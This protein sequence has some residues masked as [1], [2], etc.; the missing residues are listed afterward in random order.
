M[1]PVRYEGHPAITLCARHPPQQSRNMDP[2]CP[3]APAVKQHGFQVY[4]Y[5]VVWLSHPAIVKAAVT[6]PHRP[7]GPEEATRIPQACVVA[8]GP[9][10]STEV[11]SHQGPTHTHTHTVPFLCA[12]HAGADV[13]G[14]PRGGRSNCEQRDKPPLIVFLNPPSS[15]PAQWVGTPPPPHPR[16]EDSIPKRRT[17]TYTLL[18]V[19]GIAPTFQHGFTDLLGFCAGGARHHR[20]I[21]KLE[22]PRL[23]RIRRASQPR[24]S[25]E[26]TNG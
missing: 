3:V 6:P 24:G 14:T 10:P 17:H 8:C 16:V 4:V 2:T 20:Q 25:V 18:S 23:A 13:G 15:P 12:E 11:A 1:G 21:P 5:P 22:T 19:D 7:Q 26:A 9:E